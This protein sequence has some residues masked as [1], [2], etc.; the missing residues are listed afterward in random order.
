MGTELKQT[1]NRGVVKGK[2]SEK[3]LKFSKDDKNN[4]VGITG[5]IVV[6]TA[7]GKHQF[8]VFSNALTKSGDKNPM[9]ANILALKNEYVAE[10]DE[11]VDNPA[12]YI[13]VNFQLNVRDFIGKQ[14]T[15]V[16]AAM[17]MSLNTANRITEKDA[18]NVTED[19][20]VIVLV[21]MYN[22]MSGLPEKERDNEGDKNLEVFGV[23][24]TGAIIPYN[25]YV[26][27]DIVEDVEDI[28]K[29]GD[30]IHLTVQPQSFHVA[31]REKKKAAFGR[32]AN[33]SKGYDKVRYV[34]IG[35]ESVIDEEHEDWLDP[36][37]VGKALKERDKMLEDMEK[38]GGTNHNKA[39][40]RASAHINP[41][42]IPF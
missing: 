33:L 38:G 13:E 19:D 31:G 25:L 32:T 7:T 9:Y 20:N 15:L 29:K 30:T 6:D 39:V 42:D 4:I 21:A 11:T 40:A 28:Y 8:G 1:L 10:T 3:N 35:G 22:K 17:S 36:E 12:S 34:L 37:L 5:S 23:N 14:G 2:L 41:A 16:K 26:P 24:Y 18:E 27:D